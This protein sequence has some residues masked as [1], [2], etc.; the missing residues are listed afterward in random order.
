MKKSIL[1]LY[2]IALLAWLAVPGAR[3]QQAVV[4]ASLDSTVILIGEQ[5]RLSL[6]TEQQP[7]EVVQFPLFSDRIPGG[8]D[9]VEPLQVDTAEAADGLMYSAFEN[10]DGTYAFVLSNANQEA[11]RVTVDDGTHYFSFEVPARAAISYRWKK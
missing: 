6:E 11:Q 9:I 10:V 2:G 8:L 5:T 1:L 3:A 7:G 4:D